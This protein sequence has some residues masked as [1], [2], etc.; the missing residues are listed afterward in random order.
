MTKTFE[1]LTKKGVKFTKKLKDEGY[2]PYAMFS[3]LDGNV[4]WLMP[5]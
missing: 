1:D 5:A 4:F 3:D 2:G